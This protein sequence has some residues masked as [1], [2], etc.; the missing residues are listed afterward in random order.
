MNLDDE[1]ALDLQGIGILYFQLHPKYISNYSKRA[2]PQLHWALNYIHKLDLKGLARLVDVGCRDGLT[3]MELA[4]RY[5]GAHV[6]GIDSS[7]PFLETAN[8]NLAKHAVPNLEFRLMDP[9]HMDF[10]GKVDAIIS[11]SFFHWV[12]DK[13]TLLQTMRRSLKRG[14][15]AYFSFFADHRRER[16]D[17]CLKVVEQYEKWHPYFCGIHLGFK[18]IQSYEFANLA[19]EAGF[20]LD[21]LEF[22]EVHDIFKS[23]DKFR[24]WLTTWVAHLK[25]LPDE[26]HDPFLS[27]VVENYLEGHP[28]DAAGMIHRKDFMC[29]ATLLN[30]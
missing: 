16:F 13:L 24:E 9:L 28:M 17:S 27:D 26:L 1:T 11:F 12:A 22:V 5:P 7:I 10:H 19:H 6:I 21:K 3:T 8:E 2:I 29:E 18:E 4:R 15:K 30:L 23:R 14:G 25:Y 20:V